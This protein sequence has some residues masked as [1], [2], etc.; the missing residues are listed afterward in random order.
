MTR[1]PAASGGTHASSTRGVAVTVIAG[2]SHGVQGAVT[3]AITQPVYLDVHMP[4]GARFEQALPAKTPAMMEGYRRFLQSKPPRAFV[5]NADGQWGYSSGDDY[6][7]RALSNCQRR[8][9]DPCFF[10]AVNDDV[11]WKAPR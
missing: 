5:L 10:Y 2:A 6:L 8:T 7:S 1:W 3:R 9:G 4:K 11:V